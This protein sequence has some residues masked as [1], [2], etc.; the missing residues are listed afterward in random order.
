MTTELLI[1]IMSIVALHVAALVGG[2]LALGIMKLFG[3][4]PPSLPSGDPTETAH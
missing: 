2:G 3:R 4:T 1:V